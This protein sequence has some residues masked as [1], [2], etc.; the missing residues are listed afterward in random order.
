[1]PASETNTRWSAE[2]APQLAGEPRAAGVGQLVG[3]DAQLHPVR[4][5]GLQ[6][7]PA[8]LDREDA[9]LAEDVGEHGEAPRAAT[10][11]IISSTS[12]ST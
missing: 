5:G 6:D 1:M 3:V 2:R 9:A 11:G 12:R 10:C 4:A 7:A 8:L